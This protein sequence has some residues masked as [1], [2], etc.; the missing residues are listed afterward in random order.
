M[1]RQQQNVKARI[2]FKQ[3]LHKIV[4]IDFLKKDI[5]LCEKDCM[6]GLSVDRWQRK[7][8]SVRYALTDLLK[9]M[10]LSNKPNK[11]A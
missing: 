8:K 1:R 10:E 6:H 7:N 11:E 3:G 4:A 9:V 2:I 5:Y